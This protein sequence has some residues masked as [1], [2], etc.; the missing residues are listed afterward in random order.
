MSD[1]LITFD[2]PGVG[3]M[4]AEFMMA[5]KELGFHLYCPESYIGIFERPGSGVPQYHGGTRIQGVRHRGGA[6][7]PCAFLMEVFKNLPFKRTGVDVKI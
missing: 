3:Q 7:G 5:G 2:V 1:V 6:H 4:E